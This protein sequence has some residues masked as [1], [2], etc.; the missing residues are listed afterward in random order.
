MCALSPPC[1]NVQDLVRPAWRVPLL[2]ATASAYRAR[3][4]SAKHAPEGSGRMTVPV[5]RV[6]QGSHQT[7]VQSLQA[8]AVS[9]WPVL[10]SQHCSIVLQMPQL[11]FKPPA[12][13]HAVSRITAVDQ[14]IAYFALLVVFSDCPPGTFG[15]NCTTCI[16]GS[17]CEGGSPNGGVALI[18]A[19]PVNRFSDAGASSESE[20]WCSAGKQ[21]PL[22]CFVGSAIAAGYH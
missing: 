10:Y 14:Q 7:W 18:K 16:A 13:E 19:C 21:K 22:C 8:N 4:K 6:L 20:C 15:K 17:W 12:V 11:S 1:C 3:A 2:K 9:V 5:K